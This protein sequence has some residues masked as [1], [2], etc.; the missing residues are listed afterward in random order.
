MSQQLPGIPLPFW[1]TIFWSSF[2][3]WKLCGH[4][5]QMQPSGWGQQP[6]SLHSP[7]NTSESSGQETRLFLYLGQLRLSHLLISSSSQSSIVKNGNG[8]M[9]LCSCRH[10]HVF[11]IISQPLNT[12]ILQ[13]SFFVCFRIRKDIFKAVLW[14]EKG[15]KRRPRRIYLFDSA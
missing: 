14:P 4:G 10:S 13:L 11:S 6:S 1:R 2:P 3:H 15:Q 8:S 12:N 7:G 9:Q 5:L